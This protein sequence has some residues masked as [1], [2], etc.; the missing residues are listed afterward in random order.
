MLEI[1]RSLRGYK[2]V[3]NFLARNAVL[4]TFRPVAIIPLKPNNFHRAILYE[5]LDIFSPLTD[6]TPAT[7]MHPC[8]FGT[9]A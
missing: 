4:A 7:D 9:G 1:W 3:F 6:P 2:Q 8:A 5:C